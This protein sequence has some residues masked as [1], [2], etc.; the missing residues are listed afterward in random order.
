M[1]DKVKSQKSE[2]P[3]AA[4]PYDGERWDATDKGTHMQQ[5]IRTAA[6][7]ACV[8]VAAAGIAAAQAPAAPA[9]T[10]A[11]AKGDPAKAKAVLDAVTKA[12]IARCWASVR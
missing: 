4:R 3:P 12:S 5:I 6:L 8:S 9:A 2:G 1:F 10:D 11:P 7:A